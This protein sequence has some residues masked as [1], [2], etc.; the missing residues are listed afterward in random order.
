MNQTQSGATVSGRVKLAKPI[1]RIHRRM[2]DQCL[3][4]PKSSIKAWAAARR[5]VGAR[6]TTETLSNT[7]EVHECSPRTN[8]AGIGFFSN[9]W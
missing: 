1:L 8:P 6:N 3:S 2:V 7:S 9:R 4:I 5:L